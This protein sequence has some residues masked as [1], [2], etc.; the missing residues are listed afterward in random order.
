MIKSGSS[1]IRKFQFFEVINDPRNAIIQENEEKEKENLSKDKN[2]SN[3]EKHSI[4]LNNINI[5]GPRQM[6]TIDDLIF[7]NGRA[8]H[9]KEGGGMIRENLIMKISENE[10]IDEFRFFN[11]VYYDF[12]IKKFEEKKY[13]IVVGSNFNENNIKEVFMMTSIKIYDATS[14]IKDKNKIIPEP[15]SKKGGEP[16]PKFLKKQINLMKRLSDGKLICNNEEE[17]IEGF[18]TIQNINSFSINSSFTHAALSVDRVGIILIYGYPNL[19]ECND[20]DIGMIYLPKIMYG[21]KEV[22][23]TNLEFA[24]LNIQN[25]MKRVLYATT[26]NLIYYYIW[27]Y[28]EENNS[29][30]NQIILKELSQERIGAYSGCISV[31]GNSL[32]IGSSNDD[33]IG[34]YN[35]LEFGK[36]WFFEGKK[37]FVDYFND[38]ILFV[39]F[40][41]SE[42]YLEIYDRKNQ[43]FVY[44][45][46]DKKKI[47]GIC[48]D[49]N[50]IYILYEESLNKKYIIK[51]KE[52][53]NKDK[54]ETFFAKKFFDDA[55]L[56]AE[57]LGFDK[58]QISEISKKH[59]EYEYSKGNYEKSI[60]EYIKTIDYYDPALVIPKFL[61]K[62]KL[63]YLIKYLEIIINNMDSKI[64]DLEENKN[65]TTLLLHCYIMQEEIDKIKTFIDLKEQFFSKDLIKTVV[66]VCV[67]TENIEI[68]LSIAKQYKMIEEYLQILIINL[69]N[70]EEA[71]NILEEPEKNEFNVTNNDIIKLYIKFAEY[72]LKVDSEKEDF[73]DKFFESVLKFIET[74]KKTID[75]KDILTLMKLFMDSDKYF[76][77]LFGIMDSYNLDYNREMIYR[78]IQLYLDDLESDNKNKAYKNKIID[79]IKNEKYIGK[80]DSQYLIMLFK[81][82]KFIEGVETLIEIQKY[83]QDLLNLYMKKRE[84]EKII[85]LCVNYGSVEL[86]FWGESLNYFLNKENRQNLDKLEI[87]KLNKNLE[88]FLEKLLESKTMASVNVLDIIY[89]KNNDI[90][91]YIINSFISKSL[92]NELNSIKK[93][94]NNFNE[95]D[96]KIEKTTGEI[97]ELKTKA[98][99]FTLVKCCECDRN[100]ELP[101]IAF[102]CGHGF[103]TTCLN[104]NNNEDIECPKC[105]DEKYNAIKEIKTCK[106]FYN[107]INTSEKLE[108]VLETK[109]NKTDFI[110][111][112]YGK[113]F[114]N[115][116]DFK[117]KNI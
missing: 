45:H 31:K 1:N 83:N 70:Y 78:R 89:E 110:Y 98:Y 105:K 76:K 85:N 48:H 41:E 82:K 33:F 34:E 53:N 81:N 74:N 4:S 108:K 38:Y 93:E 3:S 109:V 26:G 66:D 77:I 29:S 18:E 84:Y 102:K 54:F 103:H 24:V 63:Q 72:F 59:A 92:E 99:S 27:K 94:E 13:F 57:N 47:I 68:G 73:S 117:G 55:V 69:N 106:N 37:T 64:K 28:D 36:T 95:Y 49:N 107:E 50:Y 58:K 115:I 39:I 97:K 80:Y 5:S 12:S 30:E 65:Y 32:L 9:E 112:L 14:F 42:S 96:K 100:I 19:L 17:K 61:E 23:I 46:T 104:L 35:N 90:P 113:G 71:I 10:I 67:E 43:F 21:E 7:I 6:L 44:Y 15:A 86:S 22:N 11:L 20:K 79:I 91:F 2:K 8:T 88:I 87:D 111:E 56:Y 40:G 51:L 114:F 62:S 25:Q 52:K 116:E 16:Y 60:E 75:K 101:S